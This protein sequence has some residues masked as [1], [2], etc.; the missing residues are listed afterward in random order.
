VR[1][2]SVS[3]LTKCLGGA[4]GLS[5]LAAVVGLFTKVVPVVHWPKLVIFA[6][7]V[8]LLLYILYFGVW[9]LVPILVDAVLLWGVLTKRWT[10]ETLPLRTFQDD[11]S[12]IHPVM[13]VPVPWIFVLT[14]VIGLGLQYLA[15]L[16]LHWPTVVTICLI[17]GIVLSIG[18]AVLAFSSLG[19]FRAAHTTTVP[20]ETPS[21][22]ITSGPY[23]YSRNPMYVSLTLIY[24][25]VAGTQFQI[26]PVILLPLVIIYLNW[27][28]IPIEETRLREVF[29]DDYLRYCANV[30]RWL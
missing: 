25:G 14:F 6:V 12:Q 19:L 11:S 23:K 30:R 28:V 1:G 17:V 29:G 10:A 16:T 4:A 7:A 8:S 13:N 2:Q 5:F 26:W 15:P 9:M 24:L 27:I 18:G 21:K 20:F 3:L 22:L